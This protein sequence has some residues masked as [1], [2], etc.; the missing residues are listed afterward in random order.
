M[1]DLKALL[2]R[3]KAA[4]GPD[5]TIDRDLSVLPGGPNFVKE[6]DGHIAYFRHSDTDERGRTM[7]FASGPT[8]SDFDGLNESAWPFYTASIDAA[9]ALVERMLPGW[10][11]VASS[12]GEEDCPSAA[13]TTPDGDFDDFTCSAATPPLALLAA[14]LSALIAREPS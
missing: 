11:W 8:G 10:P 5:R 6:R 3:V 14:L 12:L 4:T 7:A 1:S 9:L 13:V 2:E